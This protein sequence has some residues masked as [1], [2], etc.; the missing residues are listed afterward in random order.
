[1]LVSTYA[2]RGQTP[3][4]NVKQTYDHLSAIGGITPDGRIF[5][6]MQD[7]SYK[8]PDVVRF[9]QLLAAFDTG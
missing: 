5:L 1:M 7:H 6:K 2:P 4:L 3:V 8:G 9:L